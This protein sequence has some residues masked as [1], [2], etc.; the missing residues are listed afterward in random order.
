MT[1]V[2]DIAKNAAVIA[3]MTEP[4]TLNATTNPDERIL[5]VLLNRVGKRLARM[6]NSRGGGWSVLTRE[7]TFLTEDGVE[8]YAFPADFHSL[9][10]GSVWDRDSYY[11]ARGP[12]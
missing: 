7:H 1:A 6:R 12:L 3:G 2:L 8:E 5:G 10:D 9:V 4:S 11:E